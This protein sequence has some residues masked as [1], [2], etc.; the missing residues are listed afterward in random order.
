MNNVPIEIIVHHDG[1][2]RAGPSLKIVD[3]FHRQRGFPLSSLGFHVGYHFWIERDGT[4]IQTRAPNEEGAHCVG[5]NLSSIGI[6]LAGNFDVEHPTPAQIDILGKVLV[7]TCDGFDIPIT[8]ITPHRRFAAKTC[9]GS[10]LPDNWAAIVMLQ[11]KV[12]DLIATIQYL[13]THPDAIATP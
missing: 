12:R 11:Q 8:N 13:Q 6:G 1:V 7:R 2:S 10:L 9:Y 5:H 4:L 3:D